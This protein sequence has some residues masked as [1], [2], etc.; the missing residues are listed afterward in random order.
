MKLSFRKFFPNPY[1]FLALILGASLRLFF[2]DR[3]P[4]GISGDE[5]AYLFTAKIISITGHDITQLWNPLSA[6]IF[7][8]PPHQLP[9]AE[10][11]YFLSLYYWLPV[12]PFSLFF[13]R[14][15]GV[16]LSIGIV[17]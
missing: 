9:Q 15:P 13:S 5:L 14:L 4:M 8:Y 6:F 11:P 7:Q 3:I 1:F 2:L 17:A 10:L 12:V 16:L